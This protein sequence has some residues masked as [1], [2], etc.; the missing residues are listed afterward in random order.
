MYAGTN[1]TWICNCNTDY[2]CNNSLEVLI[3]N[4]LEFTVNN[5]TIL[6]LYPKYSRTES[7]IEEVD[8]AVMP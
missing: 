4:R 3:N 7:Y 5:S 1:K 2:A 6:N 8:V